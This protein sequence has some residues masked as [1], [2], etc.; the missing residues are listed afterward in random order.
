MDQFTPIV[1]EDKAAPADLVLSADPWLANQ[2]VVIDKRLFRNVLLDGKP[3]NVIPPALVPKV[4]SKRN[5]E[6]FFAPVFTHRSYRPPMT[7]D[8]KKK[9]TESWERFETDGD[10]VLNRFIS[11]QIL[12]EH[13]DTITNDEQNKLLAH[14]KS[15]QEFGKFIRQA[16]P[17]IDSVTDAGPFVRRTM[18]MD[19]LEPKMYG[20][21][22][23]A[24]ASAM[25]QAIDREMKGLGA[26]C[27]ENVLR[28][29]TRN[30]IPDLQFARGSTKSQ[31][32]EIFGKD[33]VHEFPPPKTKG[34][35]AKGQFRFT[36]PQSELTR[37]TS[38]FSS[39]AITGQRGEYIE[40]I[41]PQSD[42]DRVLSAFPQAMVPGLFN[43]Y[44]RVT[45]DRE[46]K[47][48]VL[49]LFPSAKAS[50]E[51]SG[52]LEQDTGAT[53]FNDRD[54]AI[55]YV[56][57]RLVERLNKAGINTV[58]VPAREMELL[59]DEHPERDTIRAAMSTRNETLLF[60]KQESGREGM[61]DWDLYGES[62]IHMR[63]KRGEREFLTSITVSKDPSKWHKAKESLLSEYARMFKAGELEIPPTALAPATSIVP[64]IQS[65]EI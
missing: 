3:V 25:E 22:L 4:L 18:H 13:G 38:A 32:I 65:E 43:G 35:P 12:K 11:K 51:F 41:V 61:K 1:E 39:A 46:D 56:Y 53:Q 57:G 55:T 9:R 49:T 62:T 48:N 6:D 16:I 47:D 14:Y 44:L 31:I 19:A 8:G 24:L 17:E 37:L 60:I 7:A 50:R 58:T 28:V 10:A 40:V 36:L 52:P 2:A 15:N 5:M 45:I 64:I 21:I 29:I 26:A 27:V 23:E 42:K 20:D 30:F 59:I 34:R 54:G 63:G 33:G